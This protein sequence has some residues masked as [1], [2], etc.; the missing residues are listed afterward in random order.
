MDVLSWLSSMLFG[1]ARHT[2]H[3]F[4]VLYLEGLFITVRIDGRTAVNQ[5]PDDPQLV[6]Q[7]LI[8]TELEVVIGVGRFTVDR[9]RQR[10]DL[11]LIDTLELRLWVI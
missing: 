8:T 11:F 1:V 5:C 9:K 3:S 6:L 10:A 4:Q 7:Q 2:Q